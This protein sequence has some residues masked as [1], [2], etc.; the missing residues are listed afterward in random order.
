MQF[1]HKQIKQILFNQAH[2]KPVNEGTA[3]PVCECCVRL[4]DDLPDTYNE[5]EQLCGDCEAYFQLADKA[6]K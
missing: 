1:T 6:G 5:G 3:D 2:G 4:A